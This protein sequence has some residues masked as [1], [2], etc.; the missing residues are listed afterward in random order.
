MDELQLLNKL[1]NFGEGWQIKEVSVNK[2]SQEIDIYLDYILS[3]CF[4]SQDEPSCPIYDYSK[5]RRI[6]HLDIFDY[7]VFLNFKTP[8]A[9]LSSGEVRTIPLSI[10]D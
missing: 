2:H 10:A 5:N 9:K 6:R 4:Y 8:R 3:T 7:K 1:L